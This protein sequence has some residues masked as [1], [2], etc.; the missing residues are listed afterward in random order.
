MRLPDRGFDPYRN[1]RFEF[2]KAVSGGP[3]YRFCHKFNGLPGCARANAAGLCAH[4][5]KTN[6]PPLAHACVYCREWG[7]GCLECVANKRQLP[8]REVFE[9][10][11]LRVFEVTEPKERTPYQWQMADRRWRA[12]QDK[13]LAQSGSSSSRR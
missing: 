4:E 2:V 9:E 13:A 12:Q 11:F 6:K 1:L 5:W 8:P 3:T 10:D 7:H